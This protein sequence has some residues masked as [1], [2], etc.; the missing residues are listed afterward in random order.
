MPF[1]LPCHVTVIPKQ[2]SDDFCRCSRT[3][4]IS[5]VLGADSQIHLAE[6]DHIFRRPRAAALGNGKRSG[7][8]A[9]TKRLINA[10]TRFLEFLLQTREA[11]SEGPKRCAR[12]H[13]TAI[14]LRSYADNYSEAPAAGRVTSPCERCLAT[15][16]VTKFAIVAGT[17]MA[18]ACPVITGCDVQ[19]T[20]AS[21]A[22]APPWL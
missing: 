14:L 7:C 2:A 13:T 4:L 20:A 5:P 8:D 3:P 15:L 11:P 10:E 6:A 21:E 17:A 12:N 1:A 16:A 22:M 19:K 18:V 9:G